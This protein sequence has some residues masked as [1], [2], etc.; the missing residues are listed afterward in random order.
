MTNYSSRKLELLALKWAVCNKF[1]D[2]L[3]GK[4]FTVYTDNSPLS[5]LETSKLGAVESG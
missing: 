4:E 5:H 1:K 3:V 2:Y